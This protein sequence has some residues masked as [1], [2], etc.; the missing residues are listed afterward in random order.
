MSHAQNAFA[1]AQ[2]AVEYDSS[3][4]LKAAIYFYKQ[5]VI[6]LDSAINDDPHNPDVKAWINKL[7]EYENR[8]QLLQYRGLFSPIFISKFTVKY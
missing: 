7:H 5:A 3:G 8:F 2:K 1:V 4:Q 6:F